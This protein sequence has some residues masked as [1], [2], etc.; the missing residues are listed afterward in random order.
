[1]ASEAAVPPPAALSLSGLAHPGWFGGVM[2]TAA[3][4]R[5]LV[6]AHLGPFDRLGTAISW[7]LMVI[8]ALL[9]VAAVTA[10]LL[11]LRHSP[12]TLRDRVVS[13]ILGPLFAAVPGGVFTLLLALLGHE[14]DL[15]QRPVVRG[16]VL[17]LTVLTLLLGFWLTLT[18]FVAAFEH[19]NF[20]AHS[21]SGTWFLPETVILLGVLVL[22]ALTVSFDGSAAHT[23]AAATVAVTGAGFV[24]FILTAALFFSRMVLQRQHHEPGVAA[25]WI[26]MSPLSV[27]SLALGAAAASLPH[28][29]PVDGQTVVTLVSLGSGMLWGFGLWWLAAALLLTFHH[30][31]RALAFSPG[32][33]AYVFPLSAI[34]LASAD[35]ARVWG[36]GAVAGLGVALLLFTLAVWA[37]VAVAGVRWVLRRG[38]G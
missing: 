15:L 19:D 5:A 32:S 38:W 21:I 8:A 4:S 11:S 14:P 30:G 2:G 35:L 20:E 25:V 7:V 3:L 26:L 17:V 22:H 6:G 36:S 34:S 1:M 23:L 10:G 28:V 31:R 24:L 37:A 13:P 12:D 16:A 29:L 18:F 27:S 9:F 33:W